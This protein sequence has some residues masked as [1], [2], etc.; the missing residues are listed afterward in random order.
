VGLNPGN[1]T[2]GYL[3]E[4]SFYLGNVTAGQVN[5]ALHPFGVAKPS[6]SFDWD[7]G[8]KVTSAGWQATL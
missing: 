3:S 7:K 2:A 6:T 8:G 1:G 5:S 4:V